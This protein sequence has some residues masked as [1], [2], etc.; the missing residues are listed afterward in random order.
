MSLEERGA[1]ITLLCV[2]WMEEGIP[3]DHGQLQRLLQLTSKRFEPI[4]E[5][6][7]PCWQ[8]GDNGKL[9]SPRMEKYR[10]DLRALKTKRSKAGK[11]GAAAL[12]GQTKEP[13]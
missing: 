12:H 4:W 2:A 10:R 3:T 8:D 7:A 13:V 9:I 11:A 6:L 1:H 5:H